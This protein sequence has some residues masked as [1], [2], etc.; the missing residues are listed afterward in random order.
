MS[1]G[2]ADPLERHLTPYRLNLR[3]HWPPDRPATAIRIC[4][5]GLTDNEQK[6][7]GGKRGR[8]RRVTGYQHLYVNGVEDV[9]RWMADLLV[10]PVAVAVS[11]SVS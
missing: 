1:E 9:T 3:M 5:I 8:S 10:H 7:S 4:Q 2:V 11:A 6:V